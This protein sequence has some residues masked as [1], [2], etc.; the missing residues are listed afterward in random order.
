MDLDDAHRHFRFLI[1]DRDRK[2]T[3]A[4]DAVL[5]AIDARIITTPVRAP[6]A[7]AIAERFASP[8]RRHR[9][10]RTPR[11]NPDHQPNHTP[12]PCYARSSAT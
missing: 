5:T 2:F 4:F 12:L 10:P 1:R 9:P 6:Q 7:N 3:A 8:L 11:P